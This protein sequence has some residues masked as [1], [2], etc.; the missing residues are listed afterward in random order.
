MITV[1]KSAQSMESAS[2]TTSTSTSTKLTLSL[3]D[4]T[5]KDTQ[6]SALKFSS[7]RLMSN[8][9]KRAK[10]AHGPIGQRALLRLRLLFTARSLKSA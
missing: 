8:A 7:Q 3:L 10:N 9:L 5:S 6:L 4:R 1:P 2:R